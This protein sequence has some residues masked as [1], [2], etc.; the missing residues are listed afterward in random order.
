MSW[1]SAI[2]S[3]SPGAPLRLSLRTLTVPVVVK[4]RALNAMA[5]SPLIQVSRLS[6]EMSSLH[7]AGVPFVLHERS[8]R[9]V[10]TEN[11]ITRCSPFAGPFSATAS[12]LPEPDTAEATTPDCGPMGV[13]VSETTCAVP[14]AS[15]SR[16]HRPA[17]NDPA[18]S[19]AKAKNVRSS[20]AAVTLSYDMCAG[21][22]TSA[23]VLPGERCRRPA[24]RSLSRASPLPG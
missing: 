10:V 9:P 24:G 20:A 19:V 8:A 22:V 1:L 11:T 5:L 6:C 17:S 2:R 12:S 16:Y 13:E 15:T 21:G 4:A 3:P 18:D 7:M 23:S 14:G